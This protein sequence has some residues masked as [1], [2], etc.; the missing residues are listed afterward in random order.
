ML[1][2]SIEKTL[3]ICETNLTVRNVLRSHQSVYLRDM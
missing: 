2:E 1:A 3:K